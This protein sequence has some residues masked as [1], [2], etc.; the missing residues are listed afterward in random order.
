[1]AETTTTTREWLAASRTRPAA[2]RRRWA[3]NSE[4][5]PNLKASVLFRGTASAATRCKPSASCC[6]WSRLMVAAPGPCPWHRRSDS[7]VG[8]KKKPT[9]RF[10]SG[11]GLETFSSLL[12][13][14]ALAGSARSRLHSRGSRLSGGNA[15]GGERKH[16]ERK[17]T[18]NRGIWWQAVATGICPRVTR[19]AFFGGLGDGR[20]LCRSE[21]HTS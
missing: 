10:A 20:N 21:E 1:M 12:S 7:G 18:T 8:Q 6:T 17:Y 2:R 16:I 11:G 5:P 3:P 19:W 14:S 13:V 4:V 9:A 15:R